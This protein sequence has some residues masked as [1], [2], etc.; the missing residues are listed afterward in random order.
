MRSNAKIRGGDV[1]LLVTAQSVG[2][3]CHKRHLQ[4]TCTSEVSHRVGRYKLI[5]ESTVK[6]AQVLRLIT[7]LESS[8][9]LRKQLT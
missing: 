4:R 5:A 2:S 8:S 9:I 6:H 1:H 7:T 3:T